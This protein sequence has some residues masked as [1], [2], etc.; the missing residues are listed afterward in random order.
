V[1]TQGSPQASDQQLGSAGAASATPRRASATV[2]KPAAAAAAREP[3][4]PEQDVS[5]SDDR[6]MGPGRG[7]VEAGGWRAWA[8][9]G[10]LDLPRTR[11]EEGAAR[12]ATSYSSGG[13]TPGGASSAG[14]SL[15]L[16]GMAAAH[17]GA[18]G[19]GSGSQG[20]RSSEAG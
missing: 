4:A 13:A 3:F 15:S 5:A 1:T 2:P 20:R 17:S 10:A 14:C 6:G 7:A 18:A 16:R 9:A 12:A 11:L 8:G 19:G